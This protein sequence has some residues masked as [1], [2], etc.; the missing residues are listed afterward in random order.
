MAY[1]MENPLCTEFFG[2][3]SYRLT[4]M[5]MT[6]TNR[7]LNDTFN[8]MGTNLSKVLG[9]KYTI[10]ATKSGYETEA[11]YCLVSCI[12]NNE[13]GELFVLVTAKATNGTRYS[14]YDMQEIFENFAP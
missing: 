10:V 12:R 5:K 6:Y 2:G 4:H 13:S 3:T 1:A 11:E 14:I 8:N 7:T 9:S